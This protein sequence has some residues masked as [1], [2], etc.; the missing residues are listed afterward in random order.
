MFAK[1]TLMTVCWPRVP[2]AQPCT[3]LQRKSL[4]LHLTRIALFVSTAA[5]GPF[6]HSGSCNVGALPF[7]CLS[8]H[9]SCPCCRAKH[10][11]AGV[12]V[13]QTQ[14]LSACALPSAERTWLWVLQH[15]V[16]HRPLMRLTEAQQE[17]TIAIQRTWHREVTFACR[18]SSY[19]FPQN[20]HEGSQQ[21]HAFPSPTPS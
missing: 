16:Q 13:R 5:S 17:P 18:T 10:I 12:F 19:F 20:G 14:D 7:V 9:C 1:T 11:R 4:S 8:R 3:D 6:L 2:D 21:Q 15:G